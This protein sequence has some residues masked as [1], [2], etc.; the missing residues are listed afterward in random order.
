MPSAR[1]KSLLYLKLKRFLNWGPAGNECPFPPLLQWITKADEQYSGKNADSGEWRVLLQ[2]MFILLK[3]SSE[4]R[5]AGSPCCLS[6]WLAWL[7]PFQPGSLLAGRAL[8]QAVPGWKRCTSVKKTW[9]KLSC[10][11]SSSTTTTICSS[12]GWNKMVTPQN[13]P[14][15]RTKYPFLVSFSHSLYVFY[16]FFTE[17]AVL[18]VSASI[19][20]Q[21]HGLKYKEY[22]GISTK[23]AKLIKLL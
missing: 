8:C 7:A 20:L 9:N 3:P 4:A 13:F 10:F 19:P 11:A 5:G 6:S 23:L 1:E 21:K 16:C 22:W 2:N 12:R 17:I 14:Q 18:T 15:K